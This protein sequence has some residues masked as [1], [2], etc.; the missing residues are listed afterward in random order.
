MKRV[1]FIISNQI[2]SFEK[3]FRIAKQDIDLKEDDLKKMMKENDNGEPLNLYKKKIR[4]E[5][6]VGIKI[7]LK[8][9]VV[10]EW[11]EIMNEADEINSINKR[12]LAKH[13]N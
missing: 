12:E 2:K 5:R 8:T 7:E 9:T 13:G 10:D 3:Q 4:L 11:I 6:I 1:L